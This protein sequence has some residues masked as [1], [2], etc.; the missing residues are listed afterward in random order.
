MPE[1]IKKRGRPKKIISQGNFKIVLKLF[2]G[3]KYF[4]EGATAH[5][6]LGNLNL[7]YTQV[8][9]K[10]TITVQK[11]GRQ[12][13]QFYYLSQLRKLLASKVRKVGYARQLEALLAIKGTTM[14]A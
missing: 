13:E 8:K 2:S 12:Y 3:E 1:T 7:D 9:T 14:N 4:A 5:E 10:G 11:D 6:A